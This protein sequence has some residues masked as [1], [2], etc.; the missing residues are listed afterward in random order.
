LD[1]KE[2]FGRFVLQHEDARTSA[3]SFYR[4][5]QIGPGGYERHV[6]LFRSEPLVHGAAESVAEGLRRGLEVQHSQ[7]A[8]GFEAGSLGPSAFAAFEMVEGRSVGSLIE[9]SR[10]EGHPFAAD[11]ALLIAS[12]AAAAL[13][14]AQAKKR[15]HGF[16]IPEFIQV[17]HDGEVTVRAFGLSPRLLREANYVG[18]REAG[19]LAPEVDTG[20]AP[21]IRAD[22]FSL[23]AQLFE[24]LTGQPLPRHQPCSASI[25]AA[26]IHSPGTDG[27]PLPKALGA[28]L[29]QGLAEDS[30][31]RF[32]DATAF[33]KAVDTLL[34]S[35]DYSPTTFNL[36][37]FMHTLFRDE[38]DDDSARLNAERNADY[39]PYLVPSR[40]QDGA[41]S[42]ASAPSGAAP[43]QVVVAVRPS[44]VSMPSATVRSESAG[45]TE[46]PKAEPGKSD[47]ARNDASRSESARVSRPTAAPIPQQDASSSAHSL[48][49]RAFPVV[50]VAIGVVSV[51]AI[52]IYAVMRPGPATP[53]PA[54][55]P[56]MNAAESAALA[57]VRELETR[58]AALESEKQ[59]A[60][61]KAAEEATALVEARAKARGRAVDP[62]ELQR[63]QDEARKKAQADQETRLSAERQKIED[64]R[65]RAEEARIPEGPKPEGTPAPTA[66]PSATPALAPSVSSPTN[67]PAPPESASN[68]TPAPAQAA[69][70]TPPSTAAVLLLNLSDPGVTAPQLVSQPRVDYPPMARAQRISGTVIISALVDEHGNVVEARVIQGAI[71]ANVGLNEAA[72]QSVKRRKY[73]PATLNGKVGRAWI[74]VAIEFKL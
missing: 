68:P 29:L 53:A 45:G 26:R 58:L 4:A 50:P 3:G 59:A 5:V 51:I 10:S 24:M 70:L 15:T 38:G 41:D 66:T 43:A 55:A 27:T 9:R 16:L 71:A 47:A 74:A 69:P 8:R 7:I 60:E 21:D 34:F 44:A 73:K 22:V 35:G 61:Q 30:A 56:T 64:E 19:F 37:F 11:H 52:A 63:A 57:R 39:R 17:S 62:K 25:V 33:K 6:Q 12:K 14:A 23:G 13:E 67:T 40:P 1:S 2:R 36:A 72:L 31:N 65:K 42:E 28:L 32:K 49:K 48:G 46:T 20:A 54:A 18:G